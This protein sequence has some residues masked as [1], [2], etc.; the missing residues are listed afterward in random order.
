MVAMADIN[1]VP[2]MSETAESAMVESAEAK[3]LFE[4]KLEIE[5]AWMSGRD[6]GAVHRLAGA[7]PE[8]ADELYEFFAFMVDTHAGLSH[9]R[10]VRRE[11]ELTSETAVKSGKAAKPFLG[12]LRDVTGGSVQ[13]I[14]A[15]MEVTADFL[16][17]LSDNG[18][19]L[20]VKAR[21]E[22]VRRARAVREMGEGEALASF[23]VVSLRRAA[24]R[25]TAYPVSSLTFKELVERSS[26]SAEQKGFWSGLG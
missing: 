4:C 7:H 9:Q 25:D 24:S 3:L 13:A 16:V 11:S 12:L 18:R 8:V 5:Q 22:L 14:A 15:A 1:D 17:D 21:E 26:L 19:V 2:G 10:E 20:P 6:R 23:D